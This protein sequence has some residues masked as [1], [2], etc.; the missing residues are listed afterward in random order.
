[1]KRRK[2]SMGIKVAWNRHMTASVVLSKVKEFTIEQ[3]YRDSNDRWTVRGWYNENNHFL[4]GDDFESL[5]AAQF[6]LN[7]I[8]D[9]M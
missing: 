9:R 4:F 6:F 5:A 8:Y 2:E 3:N 7:G 1:M